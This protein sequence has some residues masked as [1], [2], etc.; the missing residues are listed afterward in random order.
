MNGLGIDKVNEWYVGEIIKLIVDYSLDDIFNVDE[1]GVFF[2]LFFQYT[3]VVKG[4]YCRGGKKVK[5]RLI[6]FFCCNVLGIEKMRLLIVGRLVNL[7]CF[8]NV[9]FFFC[10]YRVNQWVWMT[11]DLFNEWLI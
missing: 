2:Q 3:F 8:K 1:I 6:V 10:D 5:Q 7:R 4:D 11:Q 9:Y